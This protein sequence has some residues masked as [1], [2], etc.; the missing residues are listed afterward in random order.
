MTVTSFYK[1]AVLDGLDDAG[2]P[3]Y[4]DAVMI[5]IFRDTTHTVER[6]AE[7]SDFE[8]YEAEYRFFEKR[9]SKDE[10]VEGFIIEM[11]PMLSPADVANLRGHGI[12]TVQQLAKMQRQGLPSPIADLVDQAKTYVKMAGAGGTQ[13]AAKVAELTEINAVLVE[14]NK[15][16]KTT[17]DNLKSKAA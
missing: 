1:A 7:D 5:R 11:W 8:L 16:L 3:F 4:R 15:L 13:L 12:R 6:L 2:L 10:V 17:I 14:E 9:H